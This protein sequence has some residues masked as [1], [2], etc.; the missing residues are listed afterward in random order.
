MDLLRLVEAF[1]HE[2]AGN[3]AVSIPQWPPDKLVVGVS[4]GA[5]SLALL[6]VLYRVWGPDNLVVAHLNHGLRRQAQAEAAFVAQTAVSWHIP[7]YVHQQDITALAQSQGLSLEEAGRQARYAFF[8]ELAAQTGAKA[9]AVGHNADDQAETVLLHLLRGTGLAGLRGME[10]A[11]P[12]PHAPDVVLLRPFLTVSRADI[13]QYCRTHHLQPVEDGSNQDTVFFRN[14]LRHHLLP[15]LANYNPQI[16]ARLQHLA[17]I[18]AADEALLVQLQ[19][20]AVETVL[21]ERQADWLAFDRAK[22]L[23]LPLSLRRRA[24]RHMLGMLRPVLQDVTFRPLEQAR[25]LIEHGTGGTQV[26]LPGGLVLLVE[27]GRILIAANLETVPVRWPQLAHHEAVPLPVPGRVA[28][29]NGW[30]LETAVL[31][32]LDRQTIWQNPDPWQAYIPYDRLPLFLR[33]RQPGERFQPLGLKGQTTRLKE[34]MIN[35]KIPA[36]LRARWPL[37]ATAQHLIWLVGHQLDAR[38]RVVDLN[39]PIIH[40]RARP[41]SQPSEKPEAA[42]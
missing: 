9:V 15:L 35:R 24:L 40:L 29:K 1:G 38:A 13:E 17:A 8:A 21:L 36:L 5:D 12:M 16:K 23:A 6:H 39:K 11:G 42:G 22:W 30:V 19:K 33:P 3:T 31:S 14:R 7:H 37:V 41:A 26:A 10:L 28:L 27:Y 34:T 2:L 18:V 4:G 25:L 32:N 20:E